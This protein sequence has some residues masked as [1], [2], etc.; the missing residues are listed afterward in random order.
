[1][2]WFIFCLFFEGC[3]EDADPELLPRDSRAA[4]EARSGT[5]GQ[6]YPRRLDPP[7][8][9]APGLQSGRQAL[10]PRD[11]GGGPFTSQDMHGRQV[12]VFGGAERAAPESDPEE[13][14]PLLR[15]FGPAEARGL[16]ANLDNPAWA[17][18]AGLTYVEM[19]DGWSTWYY[20]QWASR[21]YY[22]NTLTGEIFW[23]PPSWR[24]AIHELDPPLPPGDPPLRDP[25]LP[26]GDP[27]QPRPDGHGL[28]T[29]F[30]QL[31]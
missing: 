6:I 26:H 12:W 19:R 14:P 8:T 29:P 10:T 7:P 27:P 23:T 18:Y 28:A 9:H 4:D 1:M 3:H 16:D 24:D 21:V 11:P 30:L 25:P 13:P 5:G 20:S 22:H 31:D 15:A 17:H 2:F